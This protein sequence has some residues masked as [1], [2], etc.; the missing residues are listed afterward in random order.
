LAMAI[1]KY[2]H[3]RGGASQS[4]WRIKIR[5]ISL[6]LYHVNTNI[7]VIFLFKIEMFDLHA[8]SIFFTGTCEL[9][10]TN[11]F[12]EKKTSE[13]GCYSLIIHTYFLVVDY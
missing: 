12:E 8:V 2:G 7:F 6:E 13:K 1:S 9:D 4:T 3:W 10:T 11:L 5:Y